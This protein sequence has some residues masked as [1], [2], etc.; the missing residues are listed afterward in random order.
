MDRQRLEELQAAEEELRRRRERG[1]VSQAQFRKRQSQ[2]SQVMRDE[3]Q[4]LKAAIED[5]VKVA[6]RSDRDDLL[7]AVIRAAE[8]AGV[9]APE[10]VS[11]SD[12][13]EDT[14][15]EGTI[16]APCSITAAASSTTHAASSSGPYVSIAM[17]TPV[18][19]GVEP[20]RPTSIGESAVAFSNETSAYTSW[21]GPAQR[22]DYSVW[23]DASRF[24]RL[25]NP[26]AGIVPYLGEG[27]HSFAGR[28]FWACC[29]YT[30]NLCELALPYRHAQLRPPAYAVQRGK[31]ADARLRKLIQHSPPLQNVRY[32]KAMADARLEYREQGYI[33]GPNAAAGEEDS[34][35]LLQLQ[36][37][38]DYAERG[39]DQSKW[40][41]PSAVEYHLRRQ[42]GSVGFS[43][44]EHTLRSCDAGADS[45]SLSNVDGGGLPVVR[46]QV[47]ILVRLLVQ[48]L[49]ETFICFGDGP[50][51]RTERVSALFSGDVEESSYS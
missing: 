15:V 9:V 21:T 39:E 1:R 33:E 14:V 30:A 31:E 16:G 38:A 18:T 36:V 11:G 49:A 35:A 19:S 42:L 3:N 32:I 43:R 12:A 6:R 47:P 4:Q 37:A 25:I 8:A 17:S 7:R 28:V 40:L 45:G 27:R 29:H 20:G 24:M 51:W 34:A 22:L 23:I 26:P 13:D 50:R 10:L 2:A 5:I 46:D 41:S 48:K 44:L